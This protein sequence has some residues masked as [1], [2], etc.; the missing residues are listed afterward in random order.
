MVV[1][2]RGHFVVVVVVVFLSS[3]NKHS[4]LLSTVPRKSEPGLLSVLVLQSS[5]LYLPGEVA[6]SEE[7]EATAQTGAA[8]APSQTAVEQQ[9]Q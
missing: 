4:I 1:R 7:G 8:Q 2:V 5:F 6:Q 3:I 9:Q